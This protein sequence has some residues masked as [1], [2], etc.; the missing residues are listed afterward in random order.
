[1]ARRADAGTLIRRKSRQCQVVEVNETGEQA[2]LR[3]NLHGKPAFREIN[4][5]AMS[6]FLKTASDFGFMFIQKIVDKLITRIVRN[7][8]GWI[9]QAQR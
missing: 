6:T 5:H 7:A 2:A 9:H 3:I 8:P 1:M 4:L